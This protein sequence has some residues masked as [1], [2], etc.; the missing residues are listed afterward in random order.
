VIGSAAAMSTRTVCA[1]AASP[2]HGRRA[3][4]VEGAHQHLRPLPDNAL[5][6]VLPTSGFDWVSPTRSST[7]HPAERLDAAGGVIASAAIWG[8]QPT[9]LPRSQSTGHRM[10]DADLKA[11]SERENRG[12]PARAVRRRRPRRLE[13]RSSGP[14]PRSLIMTSLLRAVVIEAR[15][16]SCR[17]SRPCH[18]SSTCWR[19]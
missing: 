8:P 12:K 1:A 18:S 4:G 19:M 5:G 13:K 2:A 10:N 9:G 17:A 7:I 14:C 3:P 16:S 6:L 11:G 15:R